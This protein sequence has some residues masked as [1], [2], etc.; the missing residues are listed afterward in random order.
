M[1][2]PLPKAG[3]RKDPE[4]A[5]A[6][7]LF[8]D[9]PAPEAAKTAGQ[10]ITPGSGE[11]FELAELPEQIELDAR[12]ENTL[13]EPRGAAVRSRM[14]PPAPPPVDQV[15]SRTSEWGPTLLILFAW[16][17]V[18]LGVLYL[19]VS[20]ELYQAAALVFIVGGLGAIILS[21][22]ILITLERPVRI[23]PEQAARDFYGALS[24]HVPHYRRMWLLL[25][26]RGR[27]GPRFA[28]FEGFRAYW[29]K[30]L[31][32]L[33]AG[34]AGPLVPLVFQVEEFRAEKSA[35]K[36]D[37]NAQFKVK[38]SIRGRRNDGPIAT[39]PADVGFVRGPDSMWYLNDGTLEQRAPAPAPSG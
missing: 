10:H 23:T 15:W 8:Q 1:D 38:V 19:T 4:I 11:A 33:R 24:H 14:A 36:T 22:P 32:Q 7:W 13:A 12:G 2:K 3:P 5:A 27:I 34:R 35:G 37:M 28:S 31:A 30:R 18:I 29:I 6:E 20:A 39:F 17:A 16:S 21:Y 9:S 25:S 26:A